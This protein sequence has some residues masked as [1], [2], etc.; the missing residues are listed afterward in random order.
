MYFSLIS[1]NFVG[2]IGGLLGGW[3]KII[4]DKKVNNC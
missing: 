1:F 4:N 3:K 2:L